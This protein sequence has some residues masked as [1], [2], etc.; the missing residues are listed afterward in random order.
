MRSFAG[1]IGSAAVV[2]AMSHTGA[3]WAAAGDPPEPAALG[4]A[5]T[6]SP[7]SSTGSVASD[8]PP[9]TPDGPAIEFQGLK[10]P[11]KAR[12]IISVLDSGT[13]RRRCKSSNATTP[14][15]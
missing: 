7:R 8:G 3:L 12:Y 14:G 9:T 15:T 2:A 6:S 4:K 1:L 11:G 5:G 10:T 13:G